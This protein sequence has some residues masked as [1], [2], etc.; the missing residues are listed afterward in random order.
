MLSEQKQWSCIDPA[1]RHLYVYVYFLLKDVLSPD[2]YKTTVFV[3]IT[4]LFG[5][6]LTQNL[7]PTIRSYMVKF[8]VIPLRNLIVMLQNVLMG[9]LTDQ[10]A[11]I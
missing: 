8:E 6:Y 10:C 5:V 3:Q 4:S 7:Y 2:L 1:R 11:Q 9:Q